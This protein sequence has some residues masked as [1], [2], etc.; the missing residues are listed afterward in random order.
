MLLVFCVMFAG[1]L[2]VARSLYRTE[3]GGRRIDRRL[4][5]LRSES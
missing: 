4:R 3:L 1:L 5:E 2:G